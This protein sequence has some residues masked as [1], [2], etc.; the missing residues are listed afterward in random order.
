M[1]SSQLHIRCPKKQFG[2]RLTVLRRVL[3]QKYKN[4]TGVSHAYNMLVVSELKR[5]WAIFY[6]EFQVC[7]QLYAFEGCF[8]ATSGLK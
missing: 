6:E 7:N 3:A 8:G 1:L 2:H 4:I 5:A